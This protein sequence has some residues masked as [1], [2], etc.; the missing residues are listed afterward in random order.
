MRLAIVPGQ[1]SSRRH[2]CVV[3]RGGPLVGRALLEPLPIGLECRA[4]L[5]ATELQPPAD[6]ETDIDVGR[7]EAVA[8]HI[9]STAHRRVE[10][11]HHILE[12]AITRHL[13]AFG[14]REQAERSRRDGCLDRAGREEQ[15]AMI[16]CARGCAGRR[17]Q[18]RFGKGVG[19]IGADRR[20]FGDHDVAVPQ[21]RHLSH[22]VGCQIIGALHRL[23][24]EIFDAIGLAQFLHHPACD[25]P[26][27][28]RVRIQDQFGTHV[29]CSRK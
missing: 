2:R 5:H 16:I 15:P 23:E 29:R 12:A 27:R 21:R 9:G 1:P 22:R 13:A 10:R 19:Q 17:F 26:T 8:G 11:L 7:A 20:A 25:A 24:V 28:H 3:Q 4:G 6:L 18:S 14:W